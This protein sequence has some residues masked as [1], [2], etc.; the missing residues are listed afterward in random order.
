MPHLQVNGA[1][2]YYEECGQGPAIVFVHGLLFNGRMFSAQ[3]EALSPRFRC[4]TVDLR[5]HG[6]S[7]VTREGYDMDTLTDDVIA[8]ARALGA[9]PFHFVGLSMGGF[10]GMRIAARHPELVRSLSLLDTSAGPE[11]HKTIPRYRLLAR[12]GRW[13][14]F[15]IVAS[16]VLPIMFA[17]KFLAD[18]AR[19]QLREEWRRAIVAN[20]RAGI[21]RALEGV[22][23]RKAV[24]HEIPAIRCPTLVMVGD[25]DVATVPAKAQRIA[26]LIPGARLVTIQDA[27][28]SSCIEE[29][30]AVNA[31]LQRFIEANAGGTA[32]TGAPRT[33]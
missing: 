1:R 29:P 23:T 31:E 13:F 24:E 6:Q 4:I 15:G 18:P 33:G 32:T 8:L 7:E 17:P 20:S 26:S 9:T 30:A 19:S 28:H 14:G 16:K 2:L 11:P 5:G 25:H 12:V 21:P 3:V 27:G 10:I 22:V